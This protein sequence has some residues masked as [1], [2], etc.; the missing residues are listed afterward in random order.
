MF[1]LKAS[2]AFSAIS[3]VLAPSQGMNAAGMTNRAE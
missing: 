3:G 2:A 1:L